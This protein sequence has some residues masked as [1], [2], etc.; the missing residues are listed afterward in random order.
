MNEGDSINVR[1][2][3]DSVVS[4]TY[5]EVPV[6]CDALWALTATPGAV[7]IVGMLDHERRRAAVVRAEVK[8]NERETAIFHQAQTKLQAPGIQPP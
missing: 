2:A 8:L 6:L 5:D 4:V 1:L 7:A 3:D